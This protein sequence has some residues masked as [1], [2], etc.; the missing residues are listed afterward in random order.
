MA[1]PCRCD[2]RTEATLTIAGIGVNLG[3]LATC[4]PLR[5]Y[6]LAMSLTNSRFRF[7]RPSL[8]FRGPL[9]I[10][11]RGLLAVIAAGAVLGGLAA[12]ERKAPPVNAREKLQEQEQAI[13]EGMDK[14]MQDDPRDG[15]GSL[16]G[17]KP[18]TKP[19][20]KPDTEPDAKPD[21]EPG[22]KLVPKPAPRPGDGS[23]APPAEPKP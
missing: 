21:A 5:L 20:S 2:R 16:P 3:F 23:S 15:P 11:Q 10:G 7:C 9:A 17:G 1:E 12:C 19:D 6:G 18:D 8:S 4:T 14:Y 22:P 13:A